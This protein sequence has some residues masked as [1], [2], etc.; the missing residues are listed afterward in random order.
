MSATI[1]PEIRKSGL[2]GIIG[3]SWML[4][5]KPVFIKKY[6]ELS[7]GLFC[8]F[9]DKKIYSIPVDEME[10]FLESIGAFESLL[11]YKENKNKPASKIKIKKVAPVKPMVF[12]EDI[13]TRLQ[14]VIR[15]TSATE[16]R[17]HNTGHQWKIYIIRSKVLLNAGTL[18]EI[19]HLLLNEIL[20]KRKINGRCQTFKNQKPF[21][22]GK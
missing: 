10:A 3:K 19:L 12:H 8:V 17:L 9:T 16:Y 6:K 5:N 15:E 13:E 7:T 22:Y 4:N 18:K 11:A 2:E 20:D 14:E 21:T 1:T